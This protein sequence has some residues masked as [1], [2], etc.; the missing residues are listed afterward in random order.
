VYPW[1]LKVTRYPK[2]GK[3]RKWTVVELKA[4]DGA[5]KGDVVSDGAGLV[6][7]VRVA[8]GGATS[9]HFRYGY[10][11]KGKRAWHYCGHWPRS[12]L[13]DIRNARDEAR[14]LLRSGV[15][16]TVSREAERIEEQRRVREIIQAEERRRTENV[17]FQSMFDAWI[18]D[19]VARAD[20]NVELRRS[21]GK[22]VLP[23]L[24]GVRVKD[25]TEHHL[26]AVL[27]KV[28]SRGVNRTAITLS[29]D[30]RQMFA[31]AERRQ[32]WRRL[33]QEGNPATLVEV[34]KIVSPNYD[35]SGIRSR[36]LSP[37]E[38]RELR[39]RLDALANSYAD[40]SDRRSAVRP[41]L[42]ETQIA[43][44]LC[45][46]TACRIGELLQAEW[47][48][49]DLQGATWFIPKEN[50][51]GARGKKQE[52]R[53]Y[54]SAFALHQFRLLRMRTEDSPW[55]F[56]SRE[57]DAHIDIK[58]VTKQV[59]DRQ[60]RF[61]K[62]PLARRRNDNSLVLG[63]GLERWTPHDLRRTAATM[64]QGLGVTPTVIDR[65]Q[66]H[67]LAGS[68]VRRHYLTYEYADETR[69]A[70]RR[71]G[72]ALSEILSTRTAP[73]LPQYRS[74]RHQALA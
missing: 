36:T 73:R 16:P 49:V 62:G 69:E 13:E 14:R 51:K 61:R 46:S 59:G 33:L 8:D 65:C 47:R 40:A 4:I 63:G 74:T 43:I 2:S 58:T 22:D 39:D 29:Q 30:L 52:H 37:N 9:I 10:R 12:S 66:N 21:F 24:G 68:R 72:A 19:G 27:R 48:H 45:L 28:V 26:R 71:L 50:V 7:E 41:L 54:L 23:T 6:G 1:E 38:I 56:P 35:L 57:G 70:W 44:W 3:G 17:S 31:W 55:C 32:P 25:V 64:M 60:E 67:V 11:W 53:V 20:G 15:N 18:A 42:A 34:E 5:W